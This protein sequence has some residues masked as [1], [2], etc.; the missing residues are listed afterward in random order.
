MFDLH[1]TIQYVQC[2]S[3]VIRDNGYSQGQVTS[4]SADLSI[5][6][7]CLSY[8]WVVGPASFDCVRS[9][10]INVVNDIVILI[11]V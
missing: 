8:L 6:I 11:N 1:T 5:I 2:I 10:Q 3:A 7:I 4:Q 9:V